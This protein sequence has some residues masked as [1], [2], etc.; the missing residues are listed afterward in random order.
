MRAAR[1]CIIWPRT[2]RPPRRRAVA[3]NPAAAAHTNRHLADD[4]DDD[5][6]VE[7]ARKIARLMPGLSDG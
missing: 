2:A 5:V 7:L 6:R 3:A 1:C 4:D